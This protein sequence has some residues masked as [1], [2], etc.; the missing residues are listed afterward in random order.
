[1]GNSKAP[2]VVRKPSPDFPLFPHASGRWAK[3]VRGQFVYFGKTG[4]DPTGQVALSLWLNQKDDLMA[5]RKP[6]QQ[7][8]ELLTVGKLCN[9]FLASK[10]KQVDCG[11]LKPLSWKEY[12]WTCDRIV[13]VF[14]AGR[15]VSDLRA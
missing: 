1:M 4:D 15:A 8:D 12:K 13:R 10:Q 3:K 7:D 5:G 6:R 9:K 11:E 14:S 2:T